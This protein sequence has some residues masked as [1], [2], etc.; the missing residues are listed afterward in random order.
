MAFALAR[1]RPDG[2]LDSSFGSEGKVLTRFGPDG[3]A[4]AN[5]VEILPGGGLIV[6]G[7]VGGSAGLARYLPDGSLDP[8][9]SSDGKLLIRWV[10][11]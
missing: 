4:Q 8:S 9:F 10:D 3:S 2:D 6:A 11:R 7:S 1:Y 5:A